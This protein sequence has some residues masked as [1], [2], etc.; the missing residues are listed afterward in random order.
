MVKISKKEAKTKYG[1]ITT[2]VNS[3]YKYFLLK[4][5]N[6]IDNDGDLRFINRKN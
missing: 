2:G 3:Q 5:G 6:V 4:N 1:I